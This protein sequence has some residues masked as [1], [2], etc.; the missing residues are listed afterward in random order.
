MEIAVI[1]ITTIALLALAYRFYSPSIARRLGIR[2]DRPTPAHSLRDGIDYCPARMPIL[3]G[4]HFASIAGAAPIVGPI[5]AAAYGWIP[6]ILWIVVGGIFLGAVHDFA[7]LVASIRHSGRSIGEV[8]RQHVGLL[9]SRLFLFFLWATLVLLVAC[10]LAVVAKTFATVPSAATA[11]CLFIGLAVVF[12]L[13]IYR[14]C[15]SLGWM[16]LIGVCALALCMI[17]GWYWPIA[18]SANN[19]LIVLVA[20]II[21]AS[22]TPV[23]ILLQPRDYLNSFLLYALLII[24]VAGIFVARPSTSYPA[25]I[26]WVD[27]KLGSLFPI[28][29]VT[30]ACGAIS[31]FHSVVASG[32]TAKQLNRERDARPIGFGAM[33]VES[34]LAAIA[35]ITVMKLSRP[36]YTFNV[37][38]GPVDIFS[39]GVGSFLGS[40][41]LDDAHGK[42]FAAL[43]VSAFALTTLDT[44]T[45]LCRY[46][47]QEFFAPH[48][49]KRPTI[50]AS[51]RFIGTGVTVAAAAALAFSGQWK[52]IWPIFGAANQ[53]LAALALLAVSLWL[54]YQGR[55]S[56][57]LRIPM[58]VMFAITLSALAEITYRNMNGGSY[59]LGG[60]GAAL[61]ILAVT[62]V[63]EAVRSLRK[64]PCSAHMV[65]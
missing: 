11:S 25:F 65:D 10:F 48:T 8:I 58:F 5:I 44:A 12:G 22:I 47:F 62:L 56:G 41:G 49:G 54:R 38:K 14:L 60:I 36:A 19:W 21:V 24:S 42:N 18:L 28:L 27:P 30:V 9:G 57:F 16:T 7:A 51:N 50:L 46:A 1:L 64:S 35:L 39:S 26:T 43:A 63:V 20:Y 32:T 3:F 15:L 4:H 13:S 37:L 31:G 40:I 52:L 45:R 2:D 23:W 61:F 55:K 17:A 53:L 33:L 59:V 34:L 29:F 6:V